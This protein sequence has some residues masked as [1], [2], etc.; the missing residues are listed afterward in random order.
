M[1]GVACQ[2]EQR[3]HLAYQQKQSASPDRRFITCVRM[4]Q[5]SDANHPQ[6][7]VL[8]TSHTQRS[9]FHT[10]ACFLQALTTGNCFWKIRM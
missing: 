5:V 2:Y 7:V 10:V 3:S 9:L 4:P 8:D 6:R 1:I